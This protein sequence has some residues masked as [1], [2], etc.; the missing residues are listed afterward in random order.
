MANELIK[1][2]MKDLGVYRWQLADML[3]VSEMTVYRMLRHEMSDEEQNKV[4]EMLKQG[5]KTV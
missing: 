3:G 4:I 2:A 1:T 5:D